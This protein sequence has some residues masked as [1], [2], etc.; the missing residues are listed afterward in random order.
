MITY[1]LIPSSTAAMLYVQKSTDVARPQPCVYLSDEKGAV[2]GHKDVP[3]QRSELPEV[4]QDSIRA[5]FKRVFDLAHENWKQPGPS[6]R[7]LYCDTAQP[8][9]IRVEN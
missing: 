8:W 7:A 3:L 1:R 2:Y 4:V 6:P 5:H 9:E